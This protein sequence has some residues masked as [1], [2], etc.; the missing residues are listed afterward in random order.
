VQQSA[1]QQQL[2]MLRLNNRSREI[3]QKLNSF[4][5][6][7]GDLEKQVARIA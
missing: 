5:Q 6:Q 7:E 2:L 3:N 1:S 4:E